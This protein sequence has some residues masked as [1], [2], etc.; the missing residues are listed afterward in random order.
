M[1]FTRIAD[2]TATAYTV[3]VERLDPDDDP[4][5]EPAGYHSPQLLYA[6]MTPGAVVTDY[7]V[8][9]LARNLPGDA[10]WV[11]DELRDLDYDELGDA[12]APEADA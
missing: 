7:D 3:G 5:L 1:R 6:V 8:H 12:D 9:R 4:E 11:V 10:D 2:G